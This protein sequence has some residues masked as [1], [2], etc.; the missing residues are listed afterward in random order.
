MLSVFT[1]FFSEKPGFREKNINIYIFILIF[2]GVYANT[3]FPVKLVTSP[4]LFLFK[5]L[6]TQ[7]VH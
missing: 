2:F 3:T 1:T 4:A 5:T 6:C 7:V